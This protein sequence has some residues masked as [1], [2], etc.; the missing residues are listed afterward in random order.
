[1]TDAT[2]SAGIER[3]HESA[4][5]ARAA[6]KGAFAGLAA[7]AAIALAGRR[8]TGSAIA[9]INA[10]SHVLWGDEAGATNAVDVKHTVTGLLLNGGAGVFWALVHELL[11]TRLAR[12]DRAAAIA[13]G[14]AVAGLAY[15]VDYHLVPR[16]LSPGWEL[17]LS[18]R[19]VWLGFV[20]LGAALSVA[21]L[22]R[23][24]R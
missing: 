19:S 18:P 15:V 8:E 17:R 20:A 12:R 6:A 2:R 21:A 7:T 4:S 1:M 11:L 22:M 10:T 16:R 3:P 9:P 5:V 14:A 23:A 24:R 13:S